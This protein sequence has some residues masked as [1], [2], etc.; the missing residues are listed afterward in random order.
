M[1]APMVYSNSYSFSY[2]FFMRT[3]L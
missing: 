1:R 2:L 3:Q